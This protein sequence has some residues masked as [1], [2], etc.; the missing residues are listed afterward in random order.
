MKAMVFAAGKGTRLQPL[1]DHTPKALVEIGGVPMIEIILKKIIRYGFNDIIIN[2]HHYS[3]Q[4]TDFLKKNHNFGASITISDESDQL[5]ETGGGLVK[6]SYFF[7]DNKP[8]L[9]HNIDI[10][11]NIDLTAFYNFHLSSNSLAT[12]A[13][14]QRDTSR[15]LLI[16]N[17]GLL[18]GWKNNQTGETKLPVENAGTLSPIAFSALHIM[19]P[20]IFPL[21]TET[22]KFSLTD[23]YLRLARDQKIMTYRHDNDFWFDMGRTE[24]IPSAAPF[25]N[26]T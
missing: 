2:V 16:N 11:S 8:F 23:V 17:G 1:T 5:L 21:I 22:G 6:A 26:K 9:I 25:V 18:C 4:I 14:K 3:D 19:N 20:A 12:L 15:S 13:V 7:D 10:L 24:T